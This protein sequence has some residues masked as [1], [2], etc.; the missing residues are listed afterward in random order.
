MAALKNK[1]VVGSEFPNQAQI[2]RAVYDFSV[3]AGAVGSLD[4]FEASQDCAILAVY[5]NVKTTCTSGGSATVSLGIDGSA[6]SLVA[7]TAVASLTAGSLI[8]TSDVAPIVL[9]SGSK[10]KQAIAVA[11]LTAGKVEYVLEIVKF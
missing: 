6:A 1:K 5:A 2:V 9:A 8:K 7:A 11:A 4:V 3:D 10:V